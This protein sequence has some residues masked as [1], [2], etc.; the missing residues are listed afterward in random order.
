MYVYIYIYIKLDEFYKS[1]LGQTSI[2]HICS[3]GLIPA[4]LKAASEAMLFVLLLV[5]TDLQIRNNSSKFY[6]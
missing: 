2:R 3:P 4:V 6:W 5:W 1:K